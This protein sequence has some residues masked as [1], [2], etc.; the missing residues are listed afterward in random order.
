MS[1]APAAVLVF[2]AI[3]VGIPVVTLALAMVLAGRPAWPG[4]GGGRRTQP[5]IQAFLMLTVLVV[6]DAALVFLLPWAVAFGGLP[7][8]F[9]SVAG[10]F[11][12]VLTLV[13]VGYAW[14]RGALRSS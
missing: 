5:G 2:L 13:G 9:T 11:L 4:R 10:L 6:L 14:R 8:R 3:A 12:A 7:H 1:F